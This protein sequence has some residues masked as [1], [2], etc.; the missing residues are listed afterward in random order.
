MGKLRPSVVVSSTKEHWDTFECMV[1]TLHPLR[2]L[3]SSL[4]SLMLIHFIMF[5]LFPSS[6]LEK[7]EVGFTILLNIAQTAI[8]A[9]GGLEWM[10]PKNYGRFTSLFKK[11]CFALVIMAGGWRV[12]M[13]ILG[14]GWFQSWG[15]CHSPN[16]TNTCWMPDVPLGL[17]ANALSLS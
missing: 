4:C 8:D 11:H 9:L 10:A 1:C 6:H 16:L 5:Y 17:C 14:W 13:G 15:L 7:S 2:L 12:D 3:R